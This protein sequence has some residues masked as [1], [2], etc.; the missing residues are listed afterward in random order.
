V[1]GMVQ[2]ETPVS[3]LRGRASRGRADEEG[4]GSP[5]SR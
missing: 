5:A 3:G 2:A 1:A 4:K